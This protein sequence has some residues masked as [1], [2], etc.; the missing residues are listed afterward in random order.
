MAYEIDYIPVGEGEKSGDAIAIRY[1]NNLATA[2]ENQTI[3]VIDGGFEES[4][5]TL[6]Q[7]IKDYYKTN[8]VDLL[9]ST[10][11]DLD[12]SSGLC[13]V[14]EELNVGAIL[15]HKPW[16]HADEIKNMFKD[17]RITASGLEEKLEKSLQHASDLEALATKKGVTIIE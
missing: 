1:G 16:E 15:M 10:H 4:G 17:G 11:P 9:I 2:P 3:I 7:H 6:V 5:K 8:K 13:V 12:H 14:L